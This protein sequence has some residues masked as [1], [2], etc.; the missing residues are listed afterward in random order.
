MPDVPL[1]NDRDISDSQHHRLSHRDQ[2][3]GI[4]ENGNARHSSAKTVRQECTSRETHE[5]Q[6]TSQP[7]IASWADDQDLFVVDKLGDEANL[8]YG[9]LHR[10]NVPSYL[11]SGSGRVCGL[12]PDYRIDRQSSNEKHVVVSDTH[13]NYHNRR[14]KF[15]FTKVRFEKETRIRPMTLMA[16]SLHDLDANFLPLTEHKLENRRHLEDTVIGDLSS[17][18][19][20]EKHHYRSIQGKAKPLN[21]PNDSDL[22]YYGPPS[23]SEDDSRSLETDAV[24]A[25]KIALSRRVDTEP[26]NG[27]AWLD[28]IAHQDLLLEHHSKKCKV[29]IAEQLST[30]DIKLSMYE[31]ALNAVRNPK[32]KERLLLGMMEE[33]AKIWDTRKLGSRWQSVLQENPRCLGL[34]TKYIN[35][36]QTNFSTFHFD[37]LREMYTKCFRIL[38]AVESSGEGKVAEDNKIV[39]IQLYVLLRVTLCMRE[40]GFTEQS[41]AIWQAVIE[42]NCCRPNLNSEGNACGRTL[43]DLLQIFEE[44]WESEVPRIGEEGHQGWATHLLKPGH[45]PQPKSDRPLPQSTSDSLVEDWYEY[46]TAQFLQSRQPARTI[47]DTGENDPYR[48]VLFSDIDAFLLHLN[49]SSQQILMYAFLVYCHL[50]APEN[51]PSHL[52]EWWSDA[53]TRNDGLQGFET[54]LHSLRSSITDCNPNPESLRPPG[55]SLLSSSIFFGSPTSLYLSSADVLFAK[56]GTWFSKF[57]EWSI[58]CNNGQ[59]S[60]EGTRVCRIL[61]VLVGAGIGGNELAEYLLA[62]EFKLNPSTARKTAK[63]FLK[64]KPSDLRLYNAYALMEYRLAN[65]ATAESVMLTAINMSKSLESEARRE[66]ITLWQTWIWELLESTSSNEALMCLLMMADEEVKQNVPRAE[67][68]PA[69]VLRT[70][71]V[72][73]CTTWLISTNILLAFDQWT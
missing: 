49:P 72:S 40:A 54:I 47:D 33:G 16:D 67:V 56:Q 44:Y 7:S 11:R 65:T 64:K 17:S 63:K 29:S 22:E 70:Q 36:E 68:N 48:V 71:K 32:Y 39:E 4:S 3:S 66:T 35:F 59:A 61:K 15:V 14:D 43:E 23:Q 62:L 8:E 45:M 13:L 41:V 24:L 60:I 10:F 53:F 37:E 31:K 42:F 21:A 50:P 73:V 51:T 18:T 38:R 20:D 30:A 57:D 19:D 6:S 55:T 25:E 9:S 1:G 26:T 58:A 46:E 2:S 28:L 12:S 52:L 34:W 69:A 5:Q 27:D